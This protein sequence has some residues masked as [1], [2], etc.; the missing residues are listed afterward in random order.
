MA[1]V[2]PGTVAVSTRIDNAVECGIAQWRP[3]FH[4]ARLGRWRTA[5]IKRLDE[6]C[7]A[8][9]SNQCA[10]YPYCLTGWRQRRQQRDRR[11]LP[12][13][14][15][16][17]RRAHP[18]TKGALRSERSR[19]FQIT[20][21]GDRQVLRIAGRLSAPDDI[22]EPVIGIEPHL[23]TRR[24]GGKRGCASAETQPCNQTCAGRVDQQVR[25][26]GF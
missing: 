13:K 5:G 15:R 10:S 9:A 12:G 14:R 16:E 7:F 6:H 26:D 17:G 19:S 11:F 3:Q 22:G 2:T 20:T 8:G 25:P 18:V 23:A 21:D 24:I 4:L 1:T